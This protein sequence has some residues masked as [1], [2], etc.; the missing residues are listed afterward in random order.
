MTTSHD[1]ASAGRVAIV[2]GGSRG[3][4]RATVR[5][6]VSRGYA[7]VVDYLHDQR[8]AESTVEAILA[9]NGAAVAVRADVADDVDVTRLFDEAIE[10]FGGVDVVVHTVG[11]RTSPVPTRTVN[12]EAASRLRTGGAIVN[13]TSSAAALPTHGDHTATMAATEVLIRMLAL[14]L[15]ERDITVNGV[16]LA[17]DGPCAPNRIADAVAYLVSDEGH[18][19]TGHLICIDEF[20][21]LN[22]RRPPEPPTRR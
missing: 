21:A 20:E 9:G 2:T 15:R 13:L 10:A 4:G 6:L 18:G 19:L 22:L 1:E 8:A 5:R 16:A 14:E 3:A 11:S 12:R 17:V 7:V